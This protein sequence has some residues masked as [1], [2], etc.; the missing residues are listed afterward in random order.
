MTLVRFLRHAPPY[1]PGDV[2]IF[3]DATA[4]A[5]DGN[6]VVAI[7]P[8]EPAPVSAAGKAGDASPKPAKT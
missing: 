1:M 3:D 2:T 7:I 4:R 5:L 6:G 8:E